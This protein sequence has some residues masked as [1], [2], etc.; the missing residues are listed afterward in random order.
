MANLNFC[1]A[2]DVNG[3]SILFVPMYTPKEK[4]DQ[5]LKE[6]QGS[7]QHTAYVASEA[8]RSNRKYGVKIPDS[9][10][11]LILIPKWYDQATTQS[12]I[13]QEE[14]QLILM[15]GNGTADVLLDGDTLMRLVALDANLPLREPP[16]PMYSPDVFRFD[17]KHNKYMMDISGSY[18]SFI[19]TEQ[20]MYCPWC[21]CQH[22]PTQTQEE[23]DKKHTEL[24]IA[25]FRHVVNTATR[26]GKPLS[27][28]LQKIHDVIMDGHVEWRHIFDDARGYFR[29]KEIKSQA[30]CEA[31]AEID[32]TFATP[33]NDGNK[34]NN[35]RKDN[36]TNRRIS[37]SSIV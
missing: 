17:E 29:S 14:T 27:R 3:L 22:E 35:T 15:N 16:S 2:T 12:K 26:G 28:Q 18:N 25:A 7:P 8:V 11:W 1:F 24:A 23:I 36:K 4:V 33:T 6:R 31:R 10:C 19:K 9:T 21:R 5:F 20:E 37:Q 13:G 34:K 30:S 32:L